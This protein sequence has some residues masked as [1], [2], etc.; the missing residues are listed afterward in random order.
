MQFF[1]VVVQPPP[2]SSPNLSCLPKM[3]TRPHK[4]CSSPPCRSWHPPCY[5]CLWWNSSGASVSPVTFV[6]LLV[7]DLTSQNVLDVHI[8]CSRC[9]DFFPLQGWIIF[10]CVFIPCLVHSSID[11]QLCCFPLLALVNNASVNMGVQES[12]WDVTLS[13]RVCPQKWDGWVIR[14]F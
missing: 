11:R 12:L 13:V 5:W 9:Q 3:K 2:P 10:P 14:R 4:S 1:G 8:C 6:L 7:A